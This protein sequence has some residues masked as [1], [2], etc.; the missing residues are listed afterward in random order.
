MIKRKYVHFA[1]LTVVYGLFAVLFWPFNQAII[2]AVLFAFALNPLLNRLKRKYKLSDFKSISILVFCLV[3]I[4]ILPLSYVFIRG[5]NMLGKVNAEKITELPIIEKF[6]YLAHTVSEKLNSIAGA[7]GVDLS[8]IDV[9]SM[10]GNAGKSVLAVGTMIIANIPAF[11]FQFLVFIAM[12]YYLLM[13]QKRLKKS[14]MD[15]DFLSDRQVQKLIALMEDVC[16][17]V[18]ISTILIACLQAAIIALASFL[19]GYSDFLIIFMIGFFLAFV[20]VIGASP[21]TIILVAYSFLNGNYGAAVVLLIAGT[22][23]GTVD[24]LIKSYIFSSKKDSVSPLISLL[25]IIGALSLFGILGLFLGP[26]VPEL[27]VQIGQILSDKNAEE[28]G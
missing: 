17:T 22:I 13:N 11:I 3:A 25:A 14:I 23:A 7:V 16:N 15:Q 26:I 28:A 6:Q 24:N 21:L 12:L 5:A 4:L 27:A 2:L 8:Q 10:T 1:I 19:V 18:L 9:Q 20:P